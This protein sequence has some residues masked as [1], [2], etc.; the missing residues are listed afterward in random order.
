MKSVQKSSKGNSVAL[1]SIIPNTQILD[2][3]IQTSI[4]N[5]NEKIQILNN[6][7]EFMQ[8]ENS[9]VLRSNELAMYQKNELENKIKDLND[10][11]NDTKN[12]INSLQSKISYNKQ[13]I[14]SKKY[15]LNQIQNELNRRHKE[16]SSKLSILF[17]SEKKSNKEFEETKMDLESKIMNTKNEYELIKSKTESKS[18]VIIYLQKELEAAKIHNIERLEKIKEN[19]LRLE[20]FIPVSQH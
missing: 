3:S 1:N 10:Q 8:K 4:Q 2:N 19:T 16:Y 9:D 6:I 20:K 5:A 7:I 18:N 14:N 13:Q 11:L 17:D 15:D 12:E